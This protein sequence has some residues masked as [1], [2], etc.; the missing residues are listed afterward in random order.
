MN[1]D[2]IILHDVYEVFQLNL[3]TSDDQ[4]NCLK[5]N[6]HTSSKFIWFFQSDAWLAA[7]SWAVVIVVQST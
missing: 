5:M 7:Q 4:F 1:S 6:I 2:M 3:N